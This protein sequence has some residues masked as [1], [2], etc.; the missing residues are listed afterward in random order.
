LA[1]V[2]RDPSEDDA[3]EQLSLIEILARE[4][5]SGVAIQSEEGES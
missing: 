2:G 5:C 4:N 1:F 3:V